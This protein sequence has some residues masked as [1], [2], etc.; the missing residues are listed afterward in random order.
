MSHISR[1]TDSILKPSKRIP[2]YSEEKAAY[3]LDLLFDEVVVRPNRSVDR[4]DA[5]RSHVW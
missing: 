1:F 5:E 3:H 4:F 2:W